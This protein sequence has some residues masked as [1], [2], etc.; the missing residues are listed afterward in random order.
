MS[1]ELVTTV[2]KI[3]DIY[4]MKMVFSNAKCDAAACK[5]WLR[6][7]VDR[8]RFV[9]RTHACGAMTDDIYNLKLF[10]SSASPTHRVIGSGFL[11][12]Y[13]RIS[14]SVIDNTMT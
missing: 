10:D 12:Q 7:A 4:I 1:E 11:A 9:C 8:C 5:R 6:F 14:F 3:D 13:A 2:P